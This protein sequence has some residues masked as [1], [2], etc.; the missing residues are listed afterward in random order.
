[1]KQ[2]ISQL[3]FAGFL[4]LTPYFLL[5]PVLAQSADTGWEITSFNSAIT[6][7]RDTTV[8][9]T[10]TISADFGSLQKH[11]I[12]RTIPTSYRT[13]SNNT[14]NIRFHLSS[15]TGQNGNSIPVS[16]SRFGDGVKLKIG[17]PDRTV[18]RRQNYLLPFF[19][20]SPITTPT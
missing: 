1:M 4:L 8:D 6:L 19:V 14:L 12:F 2:F 20:H 7:N 11:G 18:S 3:I 17:D 10:E 16:T 9:V 13:Q 15:V 5:R